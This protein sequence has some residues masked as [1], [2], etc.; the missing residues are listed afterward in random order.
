L[1]IG[2]DQHMSS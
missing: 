2:K 1:K